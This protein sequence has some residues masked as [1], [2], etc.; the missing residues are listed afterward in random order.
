ME[1]K[2][3]NYGEV[4]ETLEEKIADIYAYFQEKYGITSGD[5]PIELAID[6]GTA[7]RYLANAIAQTLILQKGDES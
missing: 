1:P 7:T 4:L 5:Q 3:P 2:E 6:E